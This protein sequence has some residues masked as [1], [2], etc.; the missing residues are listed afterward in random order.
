MIIAPDNAKLKRVRH[1]LT[2]ASYRKQTNLYVLEHPSAIQDLI[3][4][5]PALIEFILHRE[6]VSFSCPEVAAYSVDDGLFNKLTALKTSP[7]ILAVVKKRLFDP[8]KVIAAGRCFVFLDG[9]SDPINMGAIIRNAAAFTI[10]A[11]FC[12]PGCVDPFHPESVRAAAGNLFQIPILPFDQDYWRFFPQGS[13]YGLDA[14]AK[15]SI[16]DCSF[17]A[18]TLFVFGAEG[19][20]IT[21]LDSAEVP[22][23]YIRIPISEEVESLNV[24]V[25]TGIVFYMYCRG[26]DA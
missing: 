11:I 10:D 3:K 25:S 26:I 12:A 24:A 16:K 9:V 19:A 6:S 21:S 22:V 20:G 17:A 13:V 14:Q 7:G 18:R 23:T 1:L 8:I 4:F 2:S 5:D 15:I